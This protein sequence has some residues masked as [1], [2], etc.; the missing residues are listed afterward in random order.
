VAA[1][2]EAP[3]PATQLAALRELADPFV[4][5]TAAEALAGRNA[6]AEVL[7]AW[8]VD[9]PVPAGVAEL[10]R[11]TPRER[12]QLMEALAYHQ[13]PRA[14]ELLAAGL[15]DPEASVRG[16]AGAALARVTQGRIAYDPDWQQSARQD[17]AA[18]L[19]ALHNR[20]P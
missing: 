16:S 8:P 9:L 19:R 2:A 20:A 10:A 12:S 17:A 14:I 5:S 3:L 1:W 6:R 4:L 15:D 7:R 18:K 13:D 11:G